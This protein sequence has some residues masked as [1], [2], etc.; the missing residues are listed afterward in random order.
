MRASLTRVFVGFDERQ[1]VAYNVLQ[2]SLHRYARGRVQVEP[3]ML[4]KLPMERRGLTQFTYSRFLVPYLCN[5]EGVAIF[6]DAD[7]IVKADIAELA[8]QADGVSAVQVMKEQHKFEWASVMLFN[9]DQCRVLTPEYIDDPANKLLE[10][11]FG[12]IGEFAPEWN[13]CVNRMKPREAKLY[14]YTEGI[15]LWDEVRGSPLDVV[16]DEEYEDAKSTVPWVQ[17][18]GNSVHARPVLHRFLKRKFGVEPPKAA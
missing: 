6:M 8:A 10:L 16:W 12:P 9:C 2:H 15:P 4:D 5:F 14:H 18:M 17:L 3:L 11:N 7:V 1:P 13:H